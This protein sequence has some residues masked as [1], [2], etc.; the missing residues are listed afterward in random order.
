MI[1][2]IQ[3]HQHFGP[4]VL[5]E[6][7]SWHIKPGCRVALVGP[8]GSGKTTL[9]QMAAGKLKPESGEVIRSKHTILSLFQQIPEFKPDA[10][11]IE[12][13]LD[14]N[15]L[16][17]E[18]DAKRK[19]IE[20]KFETTDHEDPAFEELLHEQ[21]DLEEFAHLHDLHGLEARAKKILSGLGFATTD[22]T[23]KTKEFS[24]GYHHRIG[25]AI[26]L[27]NPHNLL[28][29]DEPTNHLDDKTK[30][31]L[32]DYL[33]SQNQAFV[34]V[35]HDPEFLNQTVDTII[36][37]NPHGTFEFQ[38]S[39]EEFFEAKN[40]IQ[41][42]LKVQFEKEETYLKSRMEWVERFRAQATKARQVQSV[43]KRLEKRDKVDNPED[44]FWNQKPDYQ[45]QF[46]PSSNIILRLEHASFSYPDRNTGEKKTIF[47]N[48][49]IEISAGDKVALVGPNGAGK[50]TLMR[51]LLE[52]HKLDMGKLYYGPKTKLGYFSQTHGE[53][54]DESLNLVETVLKKYPELNEEKARTLLGHFAFPGDGVFKSVKHLSGGEQSRLRL[55]LLVNH[56]SNCLFLDEPTNHLDIVIR[57]AIKRALIDF[58]GSLLIISHDPDFM[59]GLCNRTFQLSGG[60]LKNLNCSFDDYLKFHKEDELGTNAKD[61]TSSKSKNE[62]KKPNPQ[63]SKN[64]RKKLEKE[65][66]DLEVQIERLEK[67]KKDKEELLQDPE[68]FK[69][70]SFQLEMDTYN[71]IKREITLLTKRWEDATIE[72]EEMGGVT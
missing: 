64:K 18:Y 15:K 54:L 32:A 16:Y 49:E 56:P 70:R 28:L 22:F 25:L 61:Q 34:L 60:E 46:V 33:V 36:E 7:F 59:K 45:F 27:L 30:S 48:A 12:T 8:N 23:R 20:S 62:E 43:I 11:V 72:L 47:E 69:N 4:K 51:C 66:S 3:I 65:I 67:N 37:I 19:T 10:S 6:G 2:F 17:A 40:E 68:F 52:Q 35:T 29:L 14:E 41:E 71:D 44:S 24:P 5:F 39:L 21:S 53:D 9:F 58:P 63:A 1:Q 42:K 26:A 50:S 13:V 38:G 57:E 31:W 55:A